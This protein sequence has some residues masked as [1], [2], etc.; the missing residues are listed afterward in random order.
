MSKIT[1]IIYL[2]DKKSWTAIINKLQSSFYLDI[3]FYYDYIDL[4]CNR[5]DEG[6][7][8]YYEEDNKIWINCFIK[9]KIILEGMSQKNQDFYDIETPYGY[10]GPLCNTEDKIFIKKANY[11]YSKWVGQKKVIVELSRFHPLIKNENNFDETVTVSLIK[12]TCSLNLNLIDRNFK[13][14]KSKI[15][16]ILKN[17]YK[18]KIRVKISNDVQDY[19]YFKKTYRKFI[20][21]K[22][23]NKEYLFN[24]IYF[25]KLFKLISKYGFISTVIDQNNN[26]ICSGIFFYG[27][28]IL[29]YHL[30][31]SDNQKRINGIFNLMIFESALHGKNIGLSR[32]HFGGGVSNDLND[33]LFKFKRSMATDTHKFYIG[34]RI[35]N[36][37]IYEK[38][39]EK[40]ESSNL[41][42]DIKHS[43]KILRYRLN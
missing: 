6:C 11:E 7:L 10:G 17:A 3:Y 22:K 9:R 12:S 37:K 5:N 21:K 30:S 40:W 8:Y 27:K 16:N 28:E 29:H 33:T 20:I 18:N 15:K 38:I 4:C 2:N 23:A 35:N 36:R 41:D 19:K 32:L 31:A 1:K 26:K 24:S 25:K 34:E 42:S 39:I 14:F 43:N 13:P